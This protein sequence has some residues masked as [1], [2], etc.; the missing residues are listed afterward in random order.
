MKADLIQSLISSHG[1]NYQ[2]EGGL[3]IYNFVG[4][5]F[6]RNHKI[7]FDQLVESQYF[8]ERKPAVRPKSKIKPMGEVDLRLE[9]Y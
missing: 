2:F 6:K 5:M 4:E 3:S 1:R 8:E 9:F 7:I